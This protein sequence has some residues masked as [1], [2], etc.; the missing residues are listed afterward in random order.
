MFTLKELEF[1]SPEYEQML[2]LRNRVLR[3]PLGR[4]LDEDDLADEESQLLFAL[5]SETGEEMLA[6]VCVRKICST[7]YKLRQMA[8]AE[9]M[10]GQGLGRHLVREVEQ[11]LAARGGDCVELH[12]R[13][14]AVGFY[15]NLG[16]Q[17]VG[18]MF[19]EV[20]IAHIKMQ[21]SLKKRETQIW[22]SL[23]NHL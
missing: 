19:S 18:P 1:S 12:A 23:N 2:T 3:H 21:K 22:V 10:R 4:I 9:P 16:Y 13:S 6:C 17:C 8:V 7:V 5:F 11:V 15:E 14:T 20:G